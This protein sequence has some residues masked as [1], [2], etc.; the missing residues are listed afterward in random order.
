MLSS[1]ARCLLHLTLNLSSIPPRPNLNRPYES[2]AEW[3]ILEGMKSKKYSVE[4]SDL[5][6]T[7]CCTLVAAGCKKFALL[8]QCT[9]REGLSMPL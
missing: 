9:Q 3:K 4:S 5:N 8:K 6:D 2:E 1:Y 7:G